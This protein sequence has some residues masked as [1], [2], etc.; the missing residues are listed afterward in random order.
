MPES[1]E[2][3]QTLR[4]NCQHPFIWAEVKNVE[5]GL[6]KILKFPVGNPTL[7]Q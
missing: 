3:K 2:L 4:L 6:E 1:E 7:K 5:I